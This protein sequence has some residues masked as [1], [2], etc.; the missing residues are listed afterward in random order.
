MANKRKLDSIRVVCI[1][2]TV[3]AQVRETILADAK[4]RGISVAKV[5]GEILT[6]WAEW[7]GKAGSNSIAK[8]GEWRGKGY[9]WDADRI[10]K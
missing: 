1:A 3:L 10:A 8:E 7:R 4:A 6:S 2:G 9:S 5:V